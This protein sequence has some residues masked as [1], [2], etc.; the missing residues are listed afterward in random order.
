ME[1]DWSLIDESCQDAWKYPFD[2]AISASL[3]AWNSEKRALRLG[4]CTLI[5]LKRPEDKVLLFCDAEEAP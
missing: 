5:S 3:F 4:L 2:K 1:V